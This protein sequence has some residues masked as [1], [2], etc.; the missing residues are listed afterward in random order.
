M[1]IDEA[2]G[3]GSEE[4]ETPVPW[5][6]LPASAQRLAVRCWHHF[7]VLAEPGM[8]AKHRVPDMGVGRGGGCCQI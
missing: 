4:A 7:P 5:A 3:K 6:D 8:D 1:G 2:L